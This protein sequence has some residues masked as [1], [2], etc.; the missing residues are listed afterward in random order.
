MRIRKRWI[1]LLAYL[2]LLAASHAWRAK[3]QEPSVPPDKQTILAP[4]FADGRA[5]EQPVRLAYRSWG[6]Q[7][8]RPGSPVVVMLHGSPGSSRDFLDLG[9]RIGERRRVIAPDLPGHGDSAN[10]PRP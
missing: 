2:I 1:L 5:M 4:V 9:A 10:R 3:Q 6:P 7:P 8:A